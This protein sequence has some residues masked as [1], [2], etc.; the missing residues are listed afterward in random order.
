MSYQWKP[1][2]SV[3]KRRREAAREMA[4]LKKKGHRVAPVVVEG[5][6][7]ANTF[8]GKSWCD[9]LESYGDF[10]NRLPRGRTYVRNGSVVD[11]QVEA[12][13]VRAWVSGSAMYQ[14][15]VKISAVSKAGWSSLCADCTGSIDSV[16]E[17]LQG[18][19][20]GGVME[21]MCRQGAG[22]FPTPKEITFKCSCP[23]WAGMC[24]HIAAAL[25]GVGVRLDESPALLFALRKVDEKDLIEKAASGIRTTKK[26]TSRKVLD[27]SELGDVFGIEIAHGTAKRGATAKAK[28]RTARAVGVAE[29][30]SP[31]VK[32]R[33]RARR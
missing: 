25:Y 6:N 24:K 22:L 11:L 20:S 21:R 4:K 12:G 26:A 17:L 18:K 3:A 10:A 32:H 16:V 27:T 19:L 5:R 14:V 8:W 23:D 7:I 31:I 33:S 15:E 2:V 9:N 29:K 28:S 1:Y 13:C 30:V